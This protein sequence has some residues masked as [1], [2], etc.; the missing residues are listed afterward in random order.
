MKSIAI[1]YEDDAHEKL[2]KALMSFLRIKTV[3]IDDE[4]CEFHPPLGSK[5]NFFK[6]EN[7]HYRLLK[8][9]ADNDVLKKILFVI[10][11][12]NSSNDQVYGGLDNSKKKLSELIEALGI[13][14]ISDYFI[15][16]NPDS[17]IGNT[18]SLLLKTQPED[19]RKC[20]EDFITCSNIKANRKSDKKFYQI[21]GLGC[22]E[23]SFYNFDHPHFNELK[24]KIYNLFDLQQQ[25]TA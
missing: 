25:A 1:V 12:D 7:D 16:Y 11:A 3:E 23:E 15:V 18:E 5:S 10:D 17:N 13:D 21:Y 4:L 8:T 20:I 14:H 19:K 2:I 9:K 22:Y 6:I 24:E